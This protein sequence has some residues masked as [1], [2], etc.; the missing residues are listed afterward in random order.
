MLFPDGNYF[1]TIQVSVKGHEFQFDSVIQKKSQEIKIVSYNSFGLTLFTLRDLPPH[2]I[3]FETS[4]SQLEEH[5]DFFLNLYP[6]I[7]KILLNSNRDEILSKKYIPLYLENIGT[8]DLVLSKIDKN[9]IPLQMTISNNSNFHLNIETTK[10][11]FFN[12]PSHF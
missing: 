10:Y 1:Q 3:E 12:S 8:S 7:K 9:K 11:I 2:P 6:S 4:V 5:K